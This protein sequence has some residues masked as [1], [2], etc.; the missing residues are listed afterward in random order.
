MK[1]AHCITTKILI[2]Q[3][4]NHYVQNS[5]SDI[6]C[7]KSTCGSLYVNGQAF[8]KTTTHIKC[9]VAQMINIVL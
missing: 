8:P 5:I 6:E 1:L 7:K 2:T 9:L 3:K 4:N